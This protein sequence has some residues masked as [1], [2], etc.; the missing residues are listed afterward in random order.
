MK[1]KYLFIFLLLTQLFSSCN[2]TSSD[3]TE[4]DYSIDGQTSEGFEDGTYCADVPIT[5]L[6]Q[7]LQMITH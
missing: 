7:A 3:V 1:K 5:I 6:I 4:D 2:N